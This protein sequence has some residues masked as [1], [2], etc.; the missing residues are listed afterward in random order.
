MEFIILA[1]SYTLVMRIDKDKIIAWFCVLSLFFIVGTALALI[2][3]LVKAF[4]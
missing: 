1:C 4:F 2:I 3:F